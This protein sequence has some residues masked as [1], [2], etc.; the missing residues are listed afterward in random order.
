MKR[1]PFATRTE[2]GKALVRFLALAFAGALSLPATGCDGTGEREVSPARRDGRA[3]TWADVA[4]ILHENCAGCHRPDGPGPFSVLDHASVRPHAARIVEMVGE[5]RMPPWPPARTEPF[6][7]ARELTDEERTALVEWAEAGAPAAD[8]AA[9]PPPPEFPKWPLGPPDLLVRAPQ[10]FVVPARGADVF[11]NFVIPAGVEEPHWIRAVDLRPGDS[12]VVHHGFVEVD[13]TGATRRLDA[14]DDI[15]GYPGMESRGAHPPDEHMLGWT[16]GRSPHAGWPGLAWQLKPGM[17]LVFLLHMLPSGTAD[18][19]RPEIG[20]YFADGPPARKPVRILLTRRDLDIRAG[21]DDYVVRDSLVIPVETELLS[22]YPHAHYIG[23]SIE[24]WAETPEGD[25]IDLIH[26]QR[27]D[28]RWQDQYYYREPL[29]LPSG[30]RVIAAWTYDNTDDNPLNP[31][32]PPRR[33]T[34]GPGSLDEMAELHLQLVALKPADRWALI[35]ARSRHVLELDD[36]DWRSMFDLGIA[37]AQR[38]D[39]GAAIQWYRRTLRMN[40]ANPQ[41]HYNLGSTLLR[42]GELENAWSHLARAVELAP[43][44]ADGYYNLGY[45]LQT[46]ERPA[47][48]VEYFATAANLDPERG[49]NWVALGNALVSAGDPPQAIRAYRRA[50]Q[51]DPRDVGALNGIGNALLAQGRVGEAVERYR[52]VLRIRP[53]DPYARSN[54]RV[55]EQQLGKP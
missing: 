33:V 31:S 43:G 40:E 23:K 19:V 39:E 15:A 22:I 3:L 5:K 48:A 41:A 27:W 12:K 2:P 50:L 37:A 45:V 53:D 17:D 51:L 54:L 30:S 4:P 11:R 1:F 34:F 6:R 18:T 9:A 14:Q 7:G 8:P 42:Q 47:E 29:R 28:F 26:I 38:G 10:G 35:E 13:E 46:A 52:E 25:R 21:D 24:A 16:P 36:R 32:D 20:F 55:A 44:M 49:R